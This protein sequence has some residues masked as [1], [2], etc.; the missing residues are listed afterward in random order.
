M[1][2]NH[3]AAVNI[4]FSSSTLTGV[5]KECPLN[6][7]QN[8]HCANNYVF[9]PMHDFFEGICPYEVKLVLNQLIFVEK[10]FSL[11]FLN[12][13]IALFDYGFTER[14]NKPSANLTDAS[15]K[16][17]SDHHMKQRAMQSWL[18]TRVICFLIGDQV[19]A[20]NEYLLLLSLLLK[21]MEIVVSPKL[22]KSILPDLQ[23]LISDH[24]NLFKEL[25]PENRLINKHHQ[26]L[27]HYPRCMRNVWSHCSFLVY[28]V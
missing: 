7:I 24:N 14:K 22:T 11:S 2:T 12:D 21:I 20:G 15:I 26:H 9:D 25:F 5:K 27:T 18:L 3:V 1:F 10:L 16:H 23:S 4:N 6:E 28:E 13:R 8:F 19:P 17:T